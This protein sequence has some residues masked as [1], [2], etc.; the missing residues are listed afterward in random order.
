MVRSSLAAVALALGSLV[1]AP[2][3]ARAAERDDEPLSPPVELRHDLRVDIPVAAGLLAATVGV[4][5]VRDDLE[6]SSCRLCDPARPADVNAVDAW[7]RE[8]LVRRDTGPANVTSYALAF[9]AA[10][11][12][13]VGLTALA[14]VVDRRGGGFLVDFL[15][16]AEGGLTAM[17]LAESLES[18]V[19][20]ERPY[21][22]ATADEAERAALVAQTGA[23]HSFPSGH[24]A[25]AFGAAAA[26]GTVASM[27]GYRLAPLVWAS[28]L[29]IGVATGYTRIA[30]DRHYFTDTLAGA[31]LGA[32]VGAGVPLLFH[33]PVA[34][35]RD[36]AG[37]PPRLWASGAP[38]SGGATLTVGGAF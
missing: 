3:A 22:R 15:V 2:G 5:L 25:A 20:R 14:A 32:L 13:A 12:S 38:T 36:V 30:A 9:G 7:F 27:R 35:E 17:L 16:M 33:R 11:A 21:V 31:G 24:V 23:F 29:M 28:G 10:P 37:A 26:S 8:S 4:R 1:A 18:I 6:P 34:R 19:L